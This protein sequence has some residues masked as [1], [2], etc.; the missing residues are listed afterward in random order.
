MEKTLSFL[1]SGVMVT[2]AMEAADAL[3][4]R[5][6][7]A[8]VVNISTI[9]PLDVAALKMYCKGMKGVVTAE[10]HSIYG[11]LGSAICEALSSEKIPIEGSWVLTMRL[12]CLRKTMRVLLQRS[13]TL[14]ADA[15]RKKSGICDYVL[16]G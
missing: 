4:K 16:N 11:G 15:Y 3:E 12:V 13:T 6:I 7:S 8:R 1:P 2:K 10:E 5:D 9:K 14:T